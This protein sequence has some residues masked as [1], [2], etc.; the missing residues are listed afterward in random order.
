M[1]LKPVKPAFIW[2]LALVML[3]S[4]EA[5]ASEARVEYLARDGTQGAVASR[6]DVPSHAWVIRVVETREKDG[7]PR[8]VTTFEWKR[9]ETPCEL[10]TLYGSDFLTALLIAQLQRPDLNDADRCYM[11]DAPRMARAI[12]HACRAHRIRNEA[13][14]LIEYMGFA[15]EGMRACEAHLTDREKQAAMQFSD[16]AYLEAMRQEL[17]RDPEAAHLGWLDIIEPPG[18]PQP[19]SGTDIQSI[20]APEMRT[21]E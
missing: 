20:S 18:L 16:P 17:L 12:E 9:P 7:R 5:L 6:S 8:E 19:R 21:E 10:F 3:A 1:D 11:D 4:A 2:C 13:D 15:A 14:F